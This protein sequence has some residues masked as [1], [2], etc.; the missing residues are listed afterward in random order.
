MK[1]TIA[2]IALAL[3]LLLN[4]DEDMIGYL[5]VS[6]GRMSDAV[7]IA[8][9][10]DHGVIIEKIH[11]E[12]PAQEAGL[13]VGDII[14]EIDKTRISGHKDLAKTVAKRPNERVA[15][16]VLRKGKQMSKMITLGER[17]ISKMHLELDIPEIPDFKVVLN[18]EEL[19]E[20]IDDL[21]EEIAELKRDIEQIK[22]DLR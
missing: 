13:E 22:K 11:D 15:I 9:D 20:L 14:M 1:R 6:T 16:S 18:T 3:P 2:I 7:K 21:T 8:L 12:S 10:M 19:Q 4:A 5:G 17:D